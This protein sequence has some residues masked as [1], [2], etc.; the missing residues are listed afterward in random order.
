MGLK[1][2]FKRKKTSDEP[3]ILKDL[4]LSKLK[5]GYFLE[6]DMKTW[7]VTSE[8]RYDWGD[9][10]V[11][12][13]WQLVT[14]DDTIFLELESDDDEYW[15]ISRK[16]PI[17]K[18]GKKIIDHIME[19]EDPPDQLDFEG[20]TFYLDESGGGRFFRDASDTGQ[21]FLK[22]D[23]VDETGDTYISIEQWGEKAFEA[24]IGKKVEEYQFTNILPGN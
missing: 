9:N 18:I 15:S 3:D 12:K 4:I 1:D 17:G 7:E 19:N 6:Y 21:E 22:W 14:S 10:D 24:S 8:S 2:F 16:I 5:K 11:T 23:F 13:E 20:E